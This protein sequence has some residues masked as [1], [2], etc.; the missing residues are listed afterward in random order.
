[1]LYILIIIVPIVIFLEIFVYIENIPNCTSIF[2]INL[3]IS[4]KYYL[5]VQRR[6]DGFDLSGPQLPQQDPVPLRA[7]L[8]YTSPSPR[9]A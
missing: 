7:C 6:E 2:K 8:L 5:D 9:D 4:R 1:M 3:F